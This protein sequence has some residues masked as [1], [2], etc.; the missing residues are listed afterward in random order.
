MAMVK[1]LVPMRQAALEVNAAILLIHHARKAS[2]VNGNSRARA[3]APDWSRAR[4]TSALWAMADGGI[5]STR[6]PNGTV[7]LTTL[8]KDHLGS[9]WT[10]KPAAGDVQ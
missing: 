10:W 2:A 6:Q 5:M 7:N 8:F 4:G 9:S 3:T 1:P